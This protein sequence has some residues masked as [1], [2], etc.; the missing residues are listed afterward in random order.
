MCGRIGSQLCCQNQMYIQNIY[1]QTIDIYLY[2]FRHHILY[3]YISVN[4]K[5]YIIY[6]VNIYIYNICKCY[7]LQKHQK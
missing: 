6:S 3:I 7:K 1:I 5:Y 2:L 4:I